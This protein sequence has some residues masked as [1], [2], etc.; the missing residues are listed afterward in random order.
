MAKKN[1]KQ[2]EPTA[3]AAST[4]ESDHA[5]VL[6]LPAEVLFADQLEA[7]RQNESDKAQTTDN[8]AGVD[9]CV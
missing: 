9:K 3:G 5:D 1:E 6:R 4:T 7:L 8:R 2:S